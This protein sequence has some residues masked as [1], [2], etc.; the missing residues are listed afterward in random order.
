MLK[1]F[2]NCI[3]T[4]CLPTLA[5]DLRSLC[6]LHVNRERI[7]GGQSLQISGFGPVVNMVKCENV[8]KGHGRNIE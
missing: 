7:P 4:L 2:D 5:A 3:K 8:P 1:F 6:K